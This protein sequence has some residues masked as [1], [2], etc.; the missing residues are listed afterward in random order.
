MKNNI[1]LIKL[2]VLLGVLSLAAGFVRVMTVPRPQSAA[3]TPP[4][5]FST[6]ATAQPSPSGLTAKVIRVAGR[7]VSVEIADTPEA[8]QQG[9]SG[10]AGLAPDKGMLFVF[11]EDGPHA[12]WMK[13]MRFSID[14]VWLAADGAV[15][16]ITHNVSPDTYP[17]SFRPSAP[18]RYVVELSAGFARKYNLKAGDKAQM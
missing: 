13:D 7:D 9:L 12:F 2:I 1:R 11:P 10:R 6:S 18:A 17:H 16:T 4:T 8:R 5:A 3:H 15:V 14:I